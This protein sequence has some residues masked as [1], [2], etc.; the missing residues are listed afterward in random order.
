MESAFPLEW[1]LDTLSANSIVSDSQSA[2]TSHPQLDEPTPPAQTGEILPVAEE[3][4]ENPQTDG[5]EVQAN[6]HRP[7]RKRAS[8]KGTVGSVPQAESNAVAGETSKKRGRPR[9]NAVDETAAEVSSSS[10]STT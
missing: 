10:Y 9:T 5:N 2:T 4:P 3:A 6:Q 8:S 7:K 1:G